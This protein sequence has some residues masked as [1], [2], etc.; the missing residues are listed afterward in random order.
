[1]LD[2]EIFLSSMQKSRL[3]RSIA[4]PLSWTIPV[5]EIIISILLFRAGTRKA[6]LYGSAILLSLFTLYLG[7]MLLFE[8]N[9]PCTCGGVLQSLSW[10]QHFLFNV[11]FIGLSIRGIQI[12][13]RQSSSLRQVKNYSNQ[14]ALP[15]P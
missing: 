3:L 11:L 8:T 14:S 15:D 4:Y 10:K 6:G 2:R 1:M 7:Y 12:E 9:L 5:L 13:I